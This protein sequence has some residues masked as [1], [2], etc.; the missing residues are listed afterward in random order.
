MA[1]KQRGILKTCGVRNALFTQSYLDEDK[2]IEAAV[3]KFSEEHGLVPI[4]QTEERALFSTVKEAIHKKIPPLLL[5]DTGAVLCVGYVMH[6][7]REYAVVHKPSEGK[8]RVLTGEGLV[9]KKDAQSDVAWIRNAAE[10]RRKQ[11][12]YRDML[13]DSSA[14]CPHSV[15]F[16]EL[17]SMDAAAIYV[18]GWKV[19]V[20]PVL[21]K[22]E[23]PTGKGDSE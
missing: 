14:E 10:W 20:S 1:A 18:Y 19:D 21:S 22:L 7:G 17:S 5:N 6:E 16:V 15:S 23:Q 4:V 13:L 9:S 2:G 11:V 8:Y 3:L 12:R